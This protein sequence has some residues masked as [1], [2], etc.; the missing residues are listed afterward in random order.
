[1][2]NIDKII[3]YEGSAD[4]KILKLSEP[5][6][7]NDKVQPACL[8]RLEFLI[9]S[10]STRC[11]ISGWGNTQKTCR[12]TEWI[13]DGVCDM[14]NNNEACQW[15]GGDCCEDN[16]VYWSSPPGHLEQCLDPNY[17]KLDK[18]DHEG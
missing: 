10:N 15:D 3:H 17:Q 12:G 6:D 18:L 16:V 13:G 11:F 7:L 14:L 5:L 4:V 1:M 2:R 9:N 8:P